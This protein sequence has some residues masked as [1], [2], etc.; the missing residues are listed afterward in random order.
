MKIKYYNLT[1]A[2]TLRALQI[3]LRRPL[4]IIE[5]LTRGQLTSMHIC[6]HVV[7]NRRGGSKS[8]ICNACIAA[9]SRAE[10]KG[11]QFFSG[12]DM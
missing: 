12:F 11:R 2:H 6:K 1:R 9:V 3:L 5:I 4:P 10:A 7:G 8:S